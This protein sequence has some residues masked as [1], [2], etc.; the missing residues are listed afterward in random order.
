L[1]A[2]FSDTGGVLVGPHDGG[3]DHHLPVDLPDRIG[4]GLGMGQQ[5]LPASIG[6]PAPEPLI[7]GLPGP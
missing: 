5:S 2:P 7:A 3:I 6:L 4:P 1:V